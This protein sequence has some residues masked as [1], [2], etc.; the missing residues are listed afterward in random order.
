M[1]VV[2]F[3]ALAIV[4]S[5]VFVATAAAD[6]PSGFT[7]SAT[8]SA[9]AAYIAGKTVTIGCPATDDAWNAYLATLP[10]PPPNGIANGYTPSI[11]GTTSYLSPEVCADLRARIQKRAVN[12]IT[13]GADLD[14]LAVEGLHL[15][16][17]Q[18]D[19]QT[20]CDALHVLPGFLVKKWGFKNHG[21]PLAIALQG[22]HEYHA[23]QSA[24]YH[25]GSCG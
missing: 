7:V 21:S 14:I 23:A 4:L 15:K 5:G 13:L 18:S 12:P 19:G 20:A 2:R 10:I 8:I 25:T 3:V 24:Q 22:A 16:G 17:E 9:R 6:I 1:S 11:G